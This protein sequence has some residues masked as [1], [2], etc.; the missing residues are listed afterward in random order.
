M[1]IQIIQLTDRWAPRH[2]AICIRSFGSLSPQ[3]KRL[4]EHLKEH[5]K[6]LTDSTGPMTK[7]RARR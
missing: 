4:V 2:F 1:A 5:S 7:R 3:A 6:A